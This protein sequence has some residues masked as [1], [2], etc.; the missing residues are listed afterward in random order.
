[1]HLLVHLFDDIQNKGVLANF[2]TKPGEQMHVS[3]RSIYNTTSKKKAT[4]D[5]EVHISLL[6]QYS[7]ELTRHRSFEKVMLQQY[8]I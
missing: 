2:S 5:K 4:V 7:N 8:T 3:L 6:F 1:M